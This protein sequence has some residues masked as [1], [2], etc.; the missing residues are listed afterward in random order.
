MTRITTIPQEAR[1]YQGKRAGVATRTVVATID[2]ITAVAATL[3]GYLV[4]AGATFLVK[5][6]SFS[7]PRVQ[8]WIGLLVTL[9]V[10]VVYLA[11][12]WAVN[13]RTYG[14]HLMGV[15]VVGWRH[16]R[17]R[18]LVALARAILCVVFPIG[19]FWCA[20]SRDSRSVQD[21]IFRSTVIYDWRPRVR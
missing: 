12:A 9:G 20:V 14:G 18:P 13:G 6:W 15:R 10:L 19:L 3:V 21:L 7:F 4:V 8:F 2:I 16:E 1:A 5:P 17:M 11:V